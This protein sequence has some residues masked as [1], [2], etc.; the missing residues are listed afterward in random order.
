MKKLLLICLVWAAAM[1]GRGQVLINLQ[2]PPSGVMVKSQLWNFSLI[3]TSTTVYDIQVEVTLTDVA[4]NQRILT[5]TSRLIQ[6]PRGAKVIKPSDVTPVTYNVTGP[7]VDASPD[8]FLPIG[9]FMTCFSVLRVNSD[10]SERL[11]EE[12][13]TIEVEPVSPPMLVLP[14]DSD[15]IEQD[16]PLF[17]W[18]PPTPFT[19]FAN[20]RYNLTLVEVAAMQTGATA[21]QQNVPLLSQSGLG[22][23]SFQY[24]LSSPALDTGKIYA[25]QVSATNNSS[26]VAQ[27]DVWTF[28]IRYPGLD[29]TTSVSKDGFYARLKREENASYV[30]SYG[31]VN[32]EYVNAYNNAAVQLRLL[33]ISGPVRR[34]VQLDSSSYAMLPGQN[35][36]TLD[37]TGNGLTSGHVYLLELTNLTGE[38]WYLKFQY[39]KPDSKNSD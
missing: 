28:R 2:L 27:S 12:C 22:T 25:W 17:T 37:L 32:F 5:G 23:T 6:L 18:I 10:V 9:R 3:N 1:A 14:A 33:D 4:T 26:V 19:F 21:L 36:R 7:G 39:R 31:K 35:L 13:E 15:H 30:L 34:T 11:A 24:P 16:R 29:T 38:H 8:G 20:L